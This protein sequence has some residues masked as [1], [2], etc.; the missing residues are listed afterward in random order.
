VPVEI[1][2]NLY[3]IFKET[4]SNIARHSNARHVRVEITRADRKFVMSISD[5]GEVVGEEIRRKGQGFRN[6]M[7]RAERIHAD[8]RIIGPPGVQMQLTM[9]EF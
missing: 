3:L 9:K 4:I 7:M 2:Q 1:R 6:M 5:D 8:L